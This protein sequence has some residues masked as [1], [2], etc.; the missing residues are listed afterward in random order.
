MDATADQDQMFGTSKAAR[1]VMTA[2]VLE[3]VG[4]AGPC[5]WQCSQV[6]ELPVVPTLRQ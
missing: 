2:A 3:D 1:H 4:V 5:L 6:H